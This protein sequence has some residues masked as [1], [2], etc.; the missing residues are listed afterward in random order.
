MI[1]LMVLKKVKLT[2]V[3]VGPLF[4]FA[5]PVP[6]VSMPTRQISVIN[7]VEKKKK[8]SVNPKKKQSEPLRLSVPKQSKLL[9]PIE[10]SCLKTQISPNK[11]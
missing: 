10:D 7:Y 5:S 9:R 1:K 8:D 3:S 2:S 6:F 11:R 4:K